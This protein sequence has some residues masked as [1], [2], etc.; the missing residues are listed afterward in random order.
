MHLEAPAIPAI[1]YSVGDLRQALPPCTSSPQA[2]YC[3]T[4][5]TLSLTITSIDQFIG[6]QVWNVEVLTYPFIVRFEPGFDGEVT[7][8]GFKGTGQIRVY[9]RAGD[10]TGLFAAEIIA[11][12]AKGSVPESRFIATPVGDFYDAEIVE[13]AGVSA[14]YLEIVDLGSSALGVESFFDLYFD[15]R[16]NDGSFPDAGRAGSMFRFASS[17]APEPPPVPEPSTFLLVSGAG[18]TALVV[19]GK[20][21]TA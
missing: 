20:K 8:G 3:L 14:G 19:R 12:N 7:A 17:S 5:T 1:V 21:S 11:L 10:V 15:L 9:G 16:F 18:L 6:S 2:P 4:D 13:N